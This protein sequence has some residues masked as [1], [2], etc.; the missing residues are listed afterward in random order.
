MKYKTTLK[1]LVSLSFLLFFLPFLKT[2]NG[3]DKVETIETIAV[4]TT[5]VAVKEV[6]NALELKTKYEQLSV[7]E[8][9]E[10][11]LS[12]VESEDSSVFSFYGL[13][14]NT[15]GNGEFDKNLLLD[16]TFYPILGYLLVLISTII[17]L[18]F[19]FFNNI[20]ATK[21]LSLINL[22]LLSISAILLYFCG[23]LESINQIKIGY[24]LIFINFI[25]IIIVSRKVL[26]GSQTV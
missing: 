22:I 26:K 12:N 11:K 1:S 8:N 9:N 14:I 13:L 2:C 4:D 15:F 21:F 24:Y 7:Q 3:V 6:D 5:N 25:L 23:V 16:K 18:G 10:R 17:M 19:S 20:K